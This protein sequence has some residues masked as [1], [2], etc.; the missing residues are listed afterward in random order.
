MVDVSLLRNRIVGILGTGACNR[1]DFQI[2]GVR[3]Y[4]PRYFA[5]AT[6]LAPSPV[7]GHGF[8]PLRV[9]V[10]NMVLAAAQYRQSDNTFLFPNTTY[11]VTPFE[12]QTIVHEAT[13][14]AFDIFRS[15][16]RSID[17]EAAAYIAE[18]LFARYSSE[19]DTMVF[20]TP[21]T[22]NELVGTHTAVPQ[23][24]SVTDAIRRVADEISY[25]VYRT[26]GVSITASQL[27]PLRRAIMA[28]PVYNFVQQN[29]NMRYLNGG[30]TF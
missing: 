2:N 16:M 14:A 5:V 6:A 1:I 10:T 26:P 12:Q 21:G 18:T 20:T 25:S 15:G 9:G 24:Q 22:G 27:S 7:P 4:W 30:V 19:A 3:I 17:E 29:P 13:H 11:G 23:I 8:R 28:H